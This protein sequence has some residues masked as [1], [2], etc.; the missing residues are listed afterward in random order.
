MSRIVTFSLKIDPLLQSPRKIWVYL[1]N[2]YAKTTKKYDV[3][4]MFDGHNLFFDK[5]AT[6]GKS[7][8]MKEYLDKHNVDLVVVGQDCNHTGNTRLDEYCPY[9]A[10][11]P[12][13]LDQA[14]NPLGEITAKWFVH[15]L[16]KECEKRF[17]IYSSRNHVGIA[18]SS[19]GGLMSAYCI[20]KYNNVFSKAACIS[21]ALYFC[22]KELFTLIEKTSFKSS[23]I[24][25]DLGSEEAK[26]KKTF[27]SRMNTLLEMNH[28]FTN[29]RC[30]TYPHLVV[31]GTHSE[32]SWETIVPVFLEFLY[33]HLF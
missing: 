14:I 24:Y 28:L 6:Y 22:D 26:N 32:S 8:G 30:E 2:S 31:D 7:W 17:R 18:G 1:P 10:I 9:P 33:P 29:K 21:P 27:V 20:S 25:M 3:L 13:W 15:V 4:Y 5:T 11:K 16:K 12:K 23:R 19:M